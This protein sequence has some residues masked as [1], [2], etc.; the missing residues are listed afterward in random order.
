MKK[1]SKAHP[2]SCP[3]IEV[4]EK[5]KKM[6]LTAHQCRTLKPTGK[7]L[8]CGVYGCAYEQAGT[9]RVIKFTSDPED[10]A[11]LQMMDKSGDSVRLY[12]GYRIAGL[13]TNRKFGKPR[14]VYAVVVQK[15]T[16][17][18]QEDAFYVDHVFGLVARS[19]AVVGLQPTKMKTK[20][21][22]KPPVLLVLPGAKA[23]IKAGCE[24]FTGRTKG[25]DKKRCLKVANRVLNIAR[26]A[27]KKGLWF[28]DSHS[29]NF[30]YANGKIVASDLGLTYAKFDKPPVSLRGLNQM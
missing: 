1:R 22:T 4:G 23:N 5:S 14:P 19:N 7:P 13:K 30:G 6:A 29:G 3:L 9:D 15:V 28:H 24:Y 26:N 25:T 8:G 17:L 11:A 2:N 10:V 12:A 20:G 27:S 18:S 21:R 16:P